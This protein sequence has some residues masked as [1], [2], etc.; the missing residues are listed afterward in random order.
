MQ[1]TLK[2]NLPFTSVKIAYDGQIVE[3]NTISQSLRLV[4]DNTCSLTIYQGGKALCPMIL[5][6]LFF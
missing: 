3:S 2:D 5:S 6:T 1:F 4:I